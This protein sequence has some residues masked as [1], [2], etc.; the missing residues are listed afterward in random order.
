MVKSPASE[1]YNSI[2]YSAVC[3][4]NAISIVGRKMKISPH[5]ASRFLPIKSI[6]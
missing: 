4:I 6:N 2:A 1:Q 5:Y 3:M